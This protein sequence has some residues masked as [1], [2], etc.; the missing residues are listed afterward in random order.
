MTVK[1]RGE[2]GDGHSHR[3][4]LRE[5]LGWLGEF[6]FVNYVRHPTRESPINH[7]VARFILG[8][9]VIWKIVWY[10]WRAFLS[11]PVLDTTTYAFVIPAPELWWVLTA[12]Q[13]LT[14]VAL[15]LFVVG[16]RLRLTAFVASTFLIHMGVVR[17]SQ[18]GSGATTPLFLAAYLLVFFA[19]YSRDNELSV[20]AVRRTA[21]QSITTLNDH[22]KATTPSS[23]GH[24]ALKWGLLTM[25]IVYFGAGWIKAIV[26]PLWAWP[27]ATNLSRIVLIE[28]FYYPSP[29]GVGEFLV[30]HPWLVTASAIGTLVL[31]LGTLAAI[32]FG[33]PLAPFVLGIFGMQA[34]IAVAIGPFFFDVYPLFLLFFTWD[35]LYRRVVSSRPVVVVYDEA[36]FFCTRSLYLFK[37]LDVNG[38]VT[39][40]SQSDLPSEYATREDHDAVDFSRSMYLFTPDDRAHEGYWAFRELLRQF[41][42]F[43]P[44][45]VLMGLGPVASVGE[46][47]YGR[48][49]ANRSTYFVCA[50]NPD[51]SS[52][53]ERRDEYG[54][55][56]G[57]SSQWSVA[58]GEE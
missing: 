14:V 1:A 54:T 8:S 5:R 4:S 10:D 30:S 38:T 34:V 55:D 46:R 44:L 12:E 24:H 48:V 28:T 15:G 29:W 2:R 52:R 42:V 56:G 19:L 43:A 39:F 33:L 6:G 37:H 47:V 11:M 13:L 49:A 7:A 27:T 36:C 31:E 18:N 21:N 41:T 25:G 58:D 53:P 57:G 16:Y 40:Y 50:I 20:D 26:G 23:H 22:L 45:V 3:R 51:D 32:L 17:Y 35:A 9:Y